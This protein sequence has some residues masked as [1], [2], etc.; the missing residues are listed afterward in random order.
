MSSLVWEL[1]RNSAYAFEY[2]SNKEKLGEPSERT[3]R[4]TL[5]NPLPS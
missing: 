3:G 5:S 2:S 1:S 4:L